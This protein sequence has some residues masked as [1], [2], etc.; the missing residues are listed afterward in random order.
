MAAATGV[1]VVG[2]TSISAEA[3]A[4]LDAVR[5]TVDGIGRV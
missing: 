5:K 3:A 1:I 4:R 2:F